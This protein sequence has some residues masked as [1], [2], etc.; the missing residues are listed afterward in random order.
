MLPDFFPLDEKKKESLRDH[1]IVLSTKPT[2]V[3][4]KYSWENDESRRESKAQAIAE[5]WMIYFGLELCDSRCSLNLG[6]VHD[7]NR[8]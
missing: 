4:K 2:S 8:A 3:G 5:S 6:T 7:M 1:R